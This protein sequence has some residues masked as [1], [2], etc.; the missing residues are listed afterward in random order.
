MN[1]DVI[2]IG[3][4]P[5]GYVSAIRSSQLGFKTAIIE[6]ENLG[7]VCLNWGCIPTKSLLRS[8]Q[9]FNYINHAQNYGLDSIDINF[10]F[11]NIIK[12]SRDIAK[13]MSN[14][15]NF[16]MKK[17]KINII[18]G[19]ARLKP[20]NK[21][22][23]LNTNQIKQYHEYHAK[24][25][26]IATGARSKKIN[27][28]PQDGIKIIGY[29]EAMSLSKQPKKLIIIGSGSIGIEFA[30]FYASIGTKVTLIE[31]L[32]RILPLEDFEISKYLEQSLKKIGINILTN[33]IIQNIDILEKKVEIFV[34][35]G[36]K[37]K[38]IHIQ[39]DIIFSAAGIQSNI[40]NIGLE[41]IGINTKN[42]KIVVDDFYKTTVNGYY[43]IGDVISTYSLAHVASAEGIVCIEKI[44]GKQV[45]KINYNNIPSCTYCIPEIASVGYTE[46]QAKKAG[47]EIKIGKFPFSAS[48]KALTNGNTDGFVKV[49][50]DKKYGEWLGCH[51]IGKGVSEMIS[52]AVTARKLETTGKEIL[53]AIHPHPTLSE[54]IIEAIANAYNHSIHI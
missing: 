37:E 2:V 19:T 31:L 52:E 51:L 48:G 16:L 3:S 26:I 25:I 38:N 23:V 4:G 41:D 47:Y 49:I 54:G 7:G 22:T 5:G 27:N 28:L 33:C 9:I 44:K 14:G 34:K 24:H 18:F 39:G 53:Q 20:G 40:E 30:Y 35:S 11:S 6:K 13:K 46:E 36:N 32:P 21:I 15:V 8:A 29:K 43:A 50:F 45:E 12:R 42:G 10:N 1:Y 17:N